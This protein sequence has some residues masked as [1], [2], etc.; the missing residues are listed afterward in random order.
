MFFNQGQAQPYFQAIAPNASLSVDN[1]AEW[2]TDVIVSADREKKGSELA[3]SYRES[4]MKKVS[5]F[6]SCGTS[7]SA[8]N[9]DHVG[10]AS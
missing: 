1:E 4:R 10:Y 2:L 8:A 6:R 3:A 9:L 5:C 7:L